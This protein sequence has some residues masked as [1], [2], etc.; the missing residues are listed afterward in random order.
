M[1]LISVPRKAAAVWQCGG[2]LRP[3]EVRVALEKMTIARTMGAM[4]TVNADQTRLLDG[5]SC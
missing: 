5:D 2:C 3:N 1:I 4:A